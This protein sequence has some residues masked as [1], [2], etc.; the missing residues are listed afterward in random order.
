MA[1][2]I[3]TLT[4]MPIQQVYVGKGDRNNKL[5]KD[6][7]Y[8]NGDPCNIFVLDFIVL[9]F[10]VRFMVM[11]FLCSASRRKCSALKHLLQM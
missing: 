5:H 2:L 10:Y 9:F 6:I 8:C 3:N 7:F 1:E 11:L 4:T